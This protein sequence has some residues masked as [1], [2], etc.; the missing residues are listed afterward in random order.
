LSADLALDPGVTYFSA[1]ESKRDIFDIAI[2]AIAFPRIHT[3]PGQGSGGIALP[4]GTY[5]FRGGYSDHWG[6]DIDVVVNP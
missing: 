2:A 6:T 5:T 1:G 3:V 4:P